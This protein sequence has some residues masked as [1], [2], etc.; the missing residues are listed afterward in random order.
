MLFSAF[1]GAGRL[2][3]WVDFFH[4]GQILSKPNDPSLPSFPRIL[5]QWLQNT[6]NSQNKFDTDCFSVIIKP[7]TRKAIHS[8]KTPMAVEASFTV[9]SSWFSVLSSSTNGIW[10]HEFGGPILM[11]LWHRLC[12]ATY[13]QIKTPCYSWCENGDCMGCEVSPGDAC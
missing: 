1:G 6:M 2:A 3:Q 13:C 12:S 9:A 5:P 7:K 10:R 8:S 11:M 4:E